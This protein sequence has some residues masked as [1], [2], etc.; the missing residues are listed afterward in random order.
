[1]S[2]VIYGWT[3]YGMER[4]G[5]LMVESCNWQWTPHEPELSWEDNDKLRSADYYA[6]VWSPFAIPHAIKL[7]HSWYGKVG[8]SYSELSTD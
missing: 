6:H 2:D 7:Y 5:K 1:M 4:L 8:W 3:S